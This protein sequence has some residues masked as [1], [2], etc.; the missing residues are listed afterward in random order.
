MSPDWANA[1]PAAAIAL[2]TTAPCASAQTVFIASPPSRPSLDV[3]DA[4]ARRQMDR[5]RIFNML[6]EFQC[7]PRLER[8]EKT[9]LT[10]S[11][12]CDPARPKRRPRPACGNGS[13]RT[14]I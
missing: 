7:G 13:Q 1:E 8:F 4:A 2:T 10:L 12:R 3:G 5:L 14:T 9:W 6:D 11:A